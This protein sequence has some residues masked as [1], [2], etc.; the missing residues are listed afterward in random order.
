MCLILT[1]LYWRIPKVR[2]TQR[3]DRP[4]R[5]V[6]NQCHVKIFSTKVCYS[7][8]YLYL[9]KITVI[10]NQDP[11]GQFATAA[12]WSNPWHY[13]P[14]DGAG[15]FLVHWRTCP[16]C[17]HAIDNPVKTFFTF[18]PRVS[19]TEVREFMRLWPLLI[20]QMKV[21]RERIG[22]IWTS[23]SCTFKSHIWVIQMQ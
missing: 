2:M 20:T 17:R 14:N 8:V 18:R 4:A 12:D 10:L 1:H 9:L 15:L 7:I 16:F 22:P 19:F 11:F 6:V 23:I 21:N 5:Y 13:K 3:R